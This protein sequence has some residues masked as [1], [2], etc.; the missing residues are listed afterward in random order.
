MKMKMFLILKVL[1]TLVRLIETNI[2][3]NWWNHKILESETQISPL[4]GSVKDQVVTF[5]KKEKIQIYGKE[6]FAHKFSLKSKDEKLN[7]NK[8]LD[9]E[10]WFE[11]KK[12]N[13]KSK[14]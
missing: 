7:E 12:F 4:S 5:L 2:I 14:I 10:I 8:K 1:P 13:I 6:Y 9:F 11:P 3:G